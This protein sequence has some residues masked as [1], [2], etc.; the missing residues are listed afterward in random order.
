MR[1]R[2]AY[3]AF[4]ALAF[5]RAVGLCCLF[6]LGTSRLQAQIIDENTPFLAPFPSVGEN[7]AFDYL[8]QS[9]VADIHRVYRIGA[10][11]RADSGG[12]EVQ[13]A[14]MG[15]DAAGL[16]DSNQILYQSALIAPSAAGGWVYD[17]GFVAVLQPG[18]VY[19]LVVDG[20]Q[21]VTGTGYTSVGVSNVFTDTQLPLYGSIDGGTTWSVAL[22][23]PMAVYV[24]GD[25]CDFNLQ[26][27]PTS[28]A[29][30]PD[31]T[32]LIQAP[33]GYPGY[34]WSTGATSNSIQVS[35]TG[36]Y[37]VTVV[38]SS[39]CRAS[40]TIDVHAAPVP[41]IGLPP[42]VETCEGASISLSVFPIYASYLW[43]TGATNEAIPADTSGL[44]WVEVVNFFG[45][46]DR[47]SSEVI[48]YPAPV[49]DIGS[50]TTLCEGQ[51]IQLDAGPGFAAYQWSNG[52]TGRSIF[53][54]AT[55]EYSVLVTAA[56]TCSARSDTV[57]VQVFPNPNDPEI[58]QT[59]IGISASFG[60][61]YLWLRDG[62]TLSVNTQEIPDPTPGSYTVIVTNG[63]GCP[64]QSLPFVIAAV[65]PGSFISEGFSPNGDGLNEVFFVEGIENYPDNVLQVFN[66]YGEEVF[67]KVKYSNDWHGLGPGGKPLPDGDYF[68]VLEL[69]PMLPTREGAVL[70]HR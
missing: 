4:S 53:V 37:D 23:N 60:F 31:D 36:F 63:F 39:F 26:V 20:Y 34:L 62:D 45:C 66:R 67:R 65:Q 68:Y 7:G 15:S 52:G 55:G 54:D 38:N 10:W 58:S 5:W 11:L 42:L 35:T 28:Y 43:N 2:P 47:D 48:Y 16:P 13:L 8:G 22:G 61:S 21:T 12:G 29:L 49:V 59:L 3:N 32:I 70:I 56:S 40:A 19:W 25:T 1:E 24:E 17:S 46:R 69:G 64:A 41:V 30:C 50:D 6:C 9:F 44:Y 51:F 27:N 18:D 14:L 57:S 33:P